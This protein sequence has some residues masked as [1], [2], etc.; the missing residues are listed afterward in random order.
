[1]GKVVQ[2]VS[3]GARH[4]MSLRARSEALSSESTVLLDLSKFW[5]S[6]GVQLGPRGHT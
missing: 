3:K 6:D 5:I 2:P 1:M 4:D